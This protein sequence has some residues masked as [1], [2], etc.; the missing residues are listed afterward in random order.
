MLENSSE[1]YG[2]SS[3]ERANGTQKKKREQNIIMPH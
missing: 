3:P 1:I 2:R